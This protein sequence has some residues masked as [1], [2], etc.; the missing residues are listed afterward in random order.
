MSRLTG[1]F[2]APPPKKAPKV[3]RDTPDEAA[4]KAYVR[5][6]DRGCVAERARQWV[7]HPSVTANHP[8]N[9]CDGPLDV[10]HVRA[11][12]GLGMKSPTHRTNMVV[13]C[14]W[15]HRLKTEYGKTWRPL[16]LAYLERVEP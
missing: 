6:R 12:G 9:L 1:P 11:S 4:E 10:D 5:A 13:L 14:R 15:H 16:L 7:H 2:A 3:K 8:Q